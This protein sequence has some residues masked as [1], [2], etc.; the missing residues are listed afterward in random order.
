MKKLQ[1]TSTKNINRVWYLNPKF[2]KILKFKNKKN[3]ALS[4]SDIVSILMGIIKMVREDERN[5][6]LAILKDIPNK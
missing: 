2:N 6:V 5:K 1:I 3:L 4:D